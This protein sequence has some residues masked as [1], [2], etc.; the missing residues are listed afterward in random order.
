MSTHTAPRT[1]IDVKNGASNTSA[2]PGIGVTNGSAVKARRCL[3]WPKI[4]HY[5]FT[6][7]R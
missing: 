2:Y 5:G 1:K 4:C 7:S 3:F 6:K